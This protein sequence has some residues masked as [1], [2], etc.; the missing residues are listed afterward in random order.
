MLNDMDIPK[1]AKKVFEGIIFDTY[2]WEQEM[3]DGSTATF[4]ALKR[5]GT[6]QVIPVVGDKIVLAQEEQPLAAKRFTYVGGRQEEGEEPIEVAKRELLEETGLESDDFELIRTYEPSGKFE[7][8]IYVFV[9]RDCR[10]VAEQGLDAGEKIELHEV[11]FDEFLKIVS[12]RD[13]WERETSNDVFRMIH[14]GTINE[15]KKQIL[16]AS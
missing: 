11:D 2:Q 3:Y 4:E 8:K 5:P 10:K 12:S 13:F 14:E 16:G 7:W 1:H 15:Y 6:V 9:A